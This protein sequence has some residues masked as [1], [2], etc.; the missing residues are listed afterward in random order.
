MDNIGT[1]FVIITWQRTGGTFLSHC[2]SRHPDV[3]CY[4][5]EVLWRKDSPRSLFPKADFLDL[6]RLFIEQPGWGAQGA[7]I[8][9][10]HASPKVLGW[11]E[12]HE[13][14]VIHLV[15]DNVVRV[16]VSKAIVMAQREISY[17]KRR[18]V[19]GSPT[20]RIV[21]DPYVVM[22]IAKEYVAERKKML[23]VLGKLKIP[24]LTVSYTDMVG[25]EGVETFRM[26]KDASHALCKFL[27]VR[28]R[29]LD[30]RLYKSGT[31]RMQDVI[32]NWDTIEAWVRASGFAY[33]LEGE[34]VG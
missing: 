24:I 21:L 23:G 20:D 25:S 1:R 29:V 5:E 28:P 9:Y 34:E 19:P 30:C 32:R 26:Q 15:R 11:L 31:R 7:K 14:R 6:I 2:L 17:P 16:A 4:R 10:G 8:I 33:C 12:S 3:Y 18:L 22:R 27:G 13:G